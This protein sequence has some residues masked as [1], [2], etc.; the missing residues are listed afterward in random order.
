M[1][2]HEVKTL[3]SAIQGQVVEMRRHLHAHP[4]L[5]FQEEQTAAYLSEQLLHWGI[6]HQKGIG[7]YGISGLLQSGPHSDPCIAL[8]AEMDALP[9]E[10]QNKVPYCSQNKGVMHACGHDVH[11]AALLGALFI[12]NQL[13]S[14]WR[15]SIR[16]IFQPGEEQLPGGANFILESGV[17][18]LPKPRAIV[19]QHVFVDLRAG[20]VGFRSGRYMAASDELFFTLKGKGGHAADPQNTNNPIFAAAALLTALGHLRSELMQLDPPAILS[21]GTIRA[22]SATNIVPETAELSGTLRT[23]D[24]PARQKVVQRISSLIQQI[25]G[26]QHVQIDFFLKKGYPVLYND[27]RITELCRQ[28][29]AAYVGKDRVAELPVRMASE[30]FAFY[31]QKIPGC[32]YRLGV[33]NPERGIIHGVHTAAFD[34]DESALEIGSGLLAWITLVLLKYFNHDS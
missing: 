30:D 26:K 18:E 19:A 3:A 10:E 28:A 25:Q 16:F 9:I 1:L 2:L 6:K 7:G 32:F 4:E 21:I 22:G 23:L 15:G 27:E 24:E 13:R 8:R 17:L 20:Q 31:L 33:G 34:I 11:M 29:A 5:S 12:L 14:E